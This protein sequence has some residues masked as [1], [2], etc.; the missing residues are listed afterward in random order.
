MWFPATLFIS[1][2]HT[3]YLGLLKMYINVTAKIFNEAC[4]MLLVIPWELTAD[5]YIYLIHH[6]CTEDLMIMHI[7]QQISTE[8]IEILEHISDVAAIHSAE[9]RENWYHDTHSLRN[10]WLKQ[11]AQLKWMNQMWFSLAVVSV[12]IN[13]RV[14]NSW[15]LWDRS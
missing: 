14:S 13:R 8:M 3:T 11:A 12:S 7:C 6:W 10:E 15:Y 2:I 1:M 4:L 9:V 5:N